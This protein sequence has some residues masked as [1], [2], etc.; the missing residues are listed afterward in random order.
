MKW[1][2]YVFCD[3]GV[4]EHIAS[5]IVAKFKVFSSSFSLSQKLEQKRLEHERQRLEQRKL[6]EEQ[7]KVLEMQQM[8]EEQDLL[9]QASNMKSGS[10]TATSLANDGHPQSSK[11]SDVSPR[12]SALK[13]VVQQPISPSVERSPPNPPRIN[14][15]SRSLPASRRNSNEADE[16]LDLEGLTLTERAESRKDNE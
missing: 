7:M 9:Q 4:H 2:W 12:A 13:K 14:S 6:F 15:A 3:L 1:I 10:T 8:K 11:S 16:W 5:I